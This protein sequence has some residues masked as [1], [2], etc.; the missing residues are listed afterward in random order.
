M[1]TEK[2]GDVEASLAQQENKDAGRSHAYKSTGAR[3]SVNPTLEVTKL[4]CK[5]QNWVVL[6]LMFFFFNYVCQVRSV[7]KVLKFLN[8]YLKGCLAIYLKHPYELRRIILNIF[9]EFAVKFLILRH[10][11]Q[12][13]FR[14]LSYKYQVNTSVI[15]NFATL[16]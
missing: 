11:R 4:E 3:D 1:V 8:V 7:W 15:R 5:D 14:Q 12:H 6:E 13:F 16:D 2:E 9:H 10:E